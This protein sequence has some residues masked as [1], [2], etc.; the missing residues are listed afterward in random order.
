MSSQ[1]LSDDCLLEVFRRVR[2]QSLMYFDSVCKTWRLASETRFLEE[3][4]EP[5]GPGLS[6]KQAWFEIMTSKFEACGSEGKILADSKE[7]QMVTGSHWVVGQ[8]GQVLTKGRWYCEITPTSSNHRQMMF[9]VF[10]GDPTAISWQKHLGYQRNGFANYAW[11]GYCMNNHNTM[12][13]AGEQW[14]LGDRCGCMID[15]DQGT[16]DFFVNDRRQPK[17]P[18][19]EA[20]FAE[21][22]AMRDRKV[23]FAA[24]LSSR[25]DAVRLLKRCPVSMMPK[26][27]E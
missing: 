11:D 3:L 2:L 10:V 19:F 9:G 20:K 12:D 27:A 22:L 17:C 7:L 23:V 18:N 21:L 26:I 16:I 15:I 13:S 25:D 4:P 1:I 8:I 14:K 24:S 6:A 5:P